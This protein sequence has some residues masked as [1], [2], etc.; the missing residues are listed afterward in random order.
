MF[1]INTDLI[2]FRLFAA[3]LLVAGLA[4]VSALVATVALGGANRQVSSLADTRVPE[5]ERAYDLKLAGQTIESTLKSLVGAR[6]I[7]EVANLEAPLSSAIEQ[8]GQSVTAIKEMVDPAKGES[9]AAAAGGLTSL[10]G[11]LEE[12]VT[13][14]LSFEDSLAQDFQTASNLKNDLSE[15][16]EAQ[17]DEADELTIETLLRILMAANQITVHY[18]EAMATSD[19]AHVTELSDSMRPVLSEL[20]SNVA[21]MGSDLPAADKANALSLLAM[22]DGDNTIF[23]R[24]IEALG[25]AKTTEANV[26]GVVARE[27][28]LFDQVDVIVEE[29]IEAVN[30]AGADTKSSINTWRIVLAVIVLAC[31][32]SSLLT[33]WLYVGRN[34]IRRLSLTSDVTRAIAEGDLDRTLPEDNSHDEIGELMAAVRVLREHGIERRR[35]EEKQAEESKARERRT[36]NLEGLIAT[37]DRS[38]NQVLD[39]MSGSSEAMSDAAKS[40]T[41]IAGSTATQSSE[42][43]VA[44]EE[45]TRRIELVAAASEELLA[46]ISEIA[47]LMQDAAGAAED[48]VIEVTKADDDAVRLAASSERVGDIIGLINNIASQTNLLALNATIEA[49]RAG[50]A[51][52]GFAV[53]ASEVK[54][55]ANQTSEA[56]GTIVQHIDEIR[57][58]SDSTVDATRS[59]GERIGKLK[60]IASAVASAVEEQRAATEEIARNSQEVAVGTRDV[61]ERIANVD[62]ATSETGGE[63]ENVLRCSDEIA[64]QCGSMRGD[65]RK[66]FEDVRA[67]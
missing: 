30:G 34:V 18:A 3:F 9:L 28:E 48:A 45:A 15:S 43:A 66:F 26:K 56:T 20:K 37:F 10:A 13:L 47:R 54:A 21:I 27:R 12:N 35:L 49:A 53:V 41:R 65:V 60:E 40:M 36:A 24:R 39:M 38:V 62:A 50:E 51:G 31:I 42:V 44:S 5:L 11:A 7:E 52:R 6:T 23:D 16:L 14:R 4:V 2:R 63:A 67:A 58:I 19:V 17:V 61:N 1:K 8:L 55:L 59:I 32:A 64:T 22:A 33:L 25:L 29:T 57:G 46:S